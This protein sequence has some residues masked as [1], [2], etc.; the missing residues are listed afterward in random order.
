MIEYLSVLSGA[1]FFAAVLC[2]L[3]AMVM[4]GVSYLAG[5]CGVVILKAWLNLNQNI[6]IGAYVLVALS[7]FCAIAMVMLES[8]ESTARAAGLGV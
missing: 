8:I 1:L 4:W 5:L 2:F 3:V 7:A 6:Y